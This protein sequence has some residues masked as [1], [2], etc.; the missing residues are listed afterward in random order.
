MHKK[1]KHSTFS[2]VTCTQCTHQ[3]HIQQV[4]TIIND[5]HLLGVDKVVT[6]TGTVKFKNHASHMLLRRLALITTVL[7]H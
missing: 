2:Y 4:Y 1:G 6:D 7:A 5:A 3:S